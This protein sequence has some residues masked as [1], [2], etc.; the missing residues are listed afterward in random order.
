M[1]LNGGACALVIRAAVSCVAFACASGCARGS[2]AQRGEMAADGRHADGAPTSANKRVVTFAS[3]SLSLR[4]VVYA[5]NGGGPFPTVLW[6]HGSYSD[7]MV[8]FDELGPRF[9]AHGWLFFGPFRRGQG[10]SASSGPNIWD[11]LDR[12]QSEGGVARRMKEMVRLL[13]GDHLND[14]LAAYAWLKAQPFAAPGRIA[15]GGNSFGGIETVLGSARVPYCA[16]IDGSGG[17]HMWARAPELRAL[18]TSAARSSLAPVFFFQAEND[19]D[20]SPNRT[21]SAA[22][23]DAGKVTEA[24][25]YPAFGASRDD[26][27]SFAWHGSS[28]WADDAL[29]F[30]ERH[31]PAKE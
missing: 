3:G 20:L 12:A 13:A 24:K 27:H 22:M 30:L 4:G 14:Q 6:N 2:A 23:L 10:L 16:A 11:E 17:A 31:C 15:V 8:A 1:L 19:F 29:R 5:P 9:A 21:L 7:P 18:M 25:V 28:V 26:G